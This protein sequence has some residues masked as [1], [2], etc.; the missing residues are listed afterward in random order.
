MLGEEINYGVGLLAGLL[1]GGI[2][3]I[4]NYVGTLYLYAFGELVQNSIE[5]KEIMSKLL[6]GTPMPAPAPK[7]APAPTPDPKPTPA[8]A[9]K[10]A[11]APVAKTFCTN[12][13]CR[14]ELDKNAAFCRFCG[15]SVMPMPK[16]EPPKP[17]PPKPA[18]A[19]K[20]ICPHCGAKQ[21]AENEKCKY[22]GTPLR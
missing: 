16:P 7:P 3:M 11:P 17:A 10:P 22:C 19:G 13:A 1:V 12:P 15:T 18:P 9:P 4:V 21:P 14:K 8:P 5:Q 2:Y 6:R 20:V